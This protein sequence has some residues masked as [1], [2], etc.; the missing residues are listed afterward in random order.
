MEKRERMRL[1]EAGIKK[2][3]QRARTGDNRGFSLLEII[4]SIVI[5]ALLLPPLLNH[6]MAAMRVNAEAKQVQNQNILAQSLM[7][8]IKGKNI[9]DIS[10]EFNYP[11]DGLDSFEAKPDGS[12]GYL[13]V[14]EGEQS[15]V[16]REESGPAGP[17]YE[18]SFTEKRDRPYYFVRKNVEYQGQVYDIL[19]TLD[20]TVYQETAAD[21]SPVGYN[22]FRLPLLKEV[23]PGKDM[24]VVQ[25]Y[26][27]EMA[28][29]VLFGNHFSYCL[30]EEEL[31][32]EEPDYNI[33][34]H[35]LEEI[36]ER[37]QKEI[38]IHIGGTEKEL[39]VEILFEFS[40][41]DIP[42]CESVS[43]QLASGPIP[44]REG[45]ILVFYLPSYQ[46][47]L[48]I[49]KDPFL[50]DLPDLHIYRQTPAPVSAQ[51]ETITIPEGIELYSNVAFPGIPAKPVKKAQA[52]NR[53]YEVKVQLFTAGTDFSPETLCLELKSTKE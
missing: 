11:K 37:L 38:S 50:T 32:K 12:G 51:P 26:E 53:I 31:H 27:E 6:F 22:S 28:A 29:T 40:C 14:Q 4:V 23:N 19:I 35:S 2:L 21:G 46:D 7:E 48:L 34:Y 39:E 42:G 24:V 15:C 43:Y 49:S 9:E 47:K 30:H 10:K 20:G 52:S 41:P 5:L 3:M 45:D 13:R 8:E 17:Y 44:D 25:S 1:K 16:R 18:Y 36:K 33:P